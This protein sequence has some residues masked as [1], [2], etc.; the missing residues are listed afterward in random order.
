MIKKRKYLYRLA[1]SVFFILLVPVILFFI[2]FWKRSYNELMKSNEIYYEEIVESYKVLLD[3]K[4]ADLKV[5]ASNISAQSKKADNLFWERPDQA[6]DAG[7]WFYNAIQEVKDYYNNHDHGVSGMG[8]YYYDADVIVTPTGSL[9]SEQYCRISNPENT[10]ELADFFAAENY[11]SY[12]MSLLI[13]NDDNI[14][15][16]FCTTMGR[17]NEKVLIFF[18]LTEADIEEIFGAVYKRGGLECYLTDREHGDRKF[19]IGDTTG[20]GTEEIFFQA[21]SRYE[22]YGLVG[23]VS[24]ASPQN[25]AVVFYHEMRFLI[26]LTVA[27][28]IISYVIIMYIAYKPVYETT[29]KLK[30]S[31]EG[32]F[33]SIDRALND[34][35]TRI[36]EQEM[37]ILDFLL[38]H[39]LYG[40]PISRDKLKRLG[41]TDAMQYFTVFLLEGYVLTNAEE[42]K[43]A[44]IMEEK[45]HAR[46]FVTDWQGEY[47]SVFILFLE[48]ENV[49][50]IKAWITKMCEK[51]KV[52]EDSLYGGKV[53]NNL[54]DI[55]ISLQQCFKEMKSKKDDGEKKGVKSREQKQKNM[56]EDILQYVEAHYR[57]PDLCQAQVADYF[58][59]STYTLS[60]IFRNQVGIGF[61][62]YI[63]AKRV[64]YAKEQLL[65]TSDSVH[66]IAVKSGF[67]NDNNFFKVFKSNTGVS[68]TTFREQ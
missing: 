4:I 55:S 49:Q 24:E 6:P 8:I 56:K 64:E 27:T 33:E 53:V 39:L 36:E 68:P 31:Q 59:I 44:S 1:V 30:A 21:D 19:Y 14:V 13:V 66:E 17:M 47:E 48:K 22:I 41:V 32:E 7:Y 28:M 38:N 51:N 61:V 67:F 58:R 11:S 29:S 35:N 65:M 2:F 18:Q 16:G 57:E 25:R 40:I 60:R 23:C 34:R 45:F 10:Q 43:L 50:D 42:K 15:I 52:S 20:E 37:L 9:S 5:Y 54:E 3:K 26:F 46:L 12:K 63:N 62:E